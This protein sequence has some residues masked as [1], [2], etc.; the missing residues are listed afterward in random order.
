MA[1]TCGVRQ[2]QEWLNSLVDQGLLQTSAEGDA[3]DRPDDLF[4][5]PN[6]GD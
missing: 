5:P 3:A 6:V 2:V 1:R 4:W